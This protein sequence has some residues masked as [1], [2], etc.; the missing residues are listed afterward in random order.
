MAFTIF[1]A[2]STLYGMDPRGSLTALTLPTGVVLDSTIS[3]RFA[4]FG[5]YVV[6]VNS[7]SRPI[8]V[9]ANLNVRLLTP[10]AP[11]SKPV[12]TGPSSGTL[13]GTFKVKQT[14]VVFDQFGQLI[15]ESDFG[16]EADAV[17]IVSK[18]LH[19][20]SLNVSGDRV[21]A[22]RLYRTTDGTAVYFKWIDLDGNTQTTIDDDVSDAGLATL[23]APRLGTAPDMS[24][25]AEF[26]RRLLGVAKA[27]PDYL[28]Y[29]EVGA[30]YAWPTDNVQPAP[31]FGSDNRGITGF[32]R[33]RDAL[34]IG[35]ENGLYQFTGT[36]DA[37]FR[38]VN[39]SED[40]GIESADS[41][42]VYKNTAFFVWKDGL[43]TWDE[44]GLN[45]ISDGKV[46]KWFTRDS[47][48]N[49]SRL[50]NSF[51]HIDPI[52]KKYRLFLA[53]AG[54]IIEDCWIEYDFVT[55]KFWGPHTSHAM[56]PSAAFR[57]A[58]PSGLS[59][60][61]VGAT[62]G[63]LRLDR[64]RRTDDAGTAID[65][66]VVTNRDDA[67]STFEA[68]LSAYEKYFG[69]LSVY[70]KPQPN[71]GTLKIQSVAGE[72]DRLRTDVYPQPDH[73]DL[74][75]SYNRMG[76]VGLG[77]AMRLRFRNNEVDTDTVLRGYEV[78]PVYLVG[79]R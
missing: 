41:V 21:S 30:M 69:E 79:R 47:T 55:G 59:I 40:A 43:Y 15:G 8:T 63:Y 65:F 31:R 44:N 7:A 48:F 67:S 73:A 38:F 4:V 29:S 32:L 14:F 61:I 75:K 58:A 72:A 20:A 54:S 53:S 52:R 46:R 64:K 45:N 1:Q 42:A 26:R 16:P 57:F 12:L 24:M 50:K 70:T 35:R 2:G 74:T 11:V 62:D 36:S 6:L 13:S 77:K 27:T 33:R 17:T 25:I 56:N 5:N 37:D 76:R 60:P 9:D 78:D 34:G 3:A 10:S 18:L 23:A 71:G 22:T 51:G 39:I 49:L 19:A 28:N 68:S 66:D